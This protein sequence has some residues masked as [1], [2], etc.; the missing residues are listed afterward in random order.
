[1]AFTLVSL[2]LDK[3]GTLIFITAST[4]VLLSLLVT[5]EGVYQKKYLN[6][7]ECLAILNLGLLSTLAAVFQNN[8]DNEQVVTIISVS[9]A[10]ASFAGILLFHVLMRFSHTKIFTKL[11]KICI[12]RNTSEESSRL[13][14]DEGDMVEQLVEPT[15][16]EVC[17]K[18]E[19]LIY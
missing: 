4:T 14:D 9:I 3:F 10:L 13:I 5:S 18:R 1:M 15:T 17:L 2:H 8:S 19:T 6:M 7:L 12:F 16:S 11:V